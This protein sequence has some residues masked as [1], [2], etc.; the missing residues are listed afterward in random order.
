MADDLIY[1]TD[2]TPNWLSNVDGLGMACLG[3]TILLT[4]VSILAV[5]LRMF[6]RIEAGATGI[7]D[8][9]MVIATGLF[10]TDSIFAC[11][12]VYASLGSHDAREDLTDWNKSA[13]VM[14][15]I[16]WQIAYAWCL[17]FIKCSICFSLFRITSELKYRLLL[18]AVMVL[19]TV[20]AM[21]GFI[22]VVITCQP[23]AKNWDPVIQAD[24]N[25]GYCMTGN[26]VQNLSYYVSASSIVTDWACAIIPCFIVWNLQMKR[27]LKISVAAILALGA[28]ASVTTIVR[29]PYLSAYTAPTDA[30][31]QIANI[32]IWSEIECGVGI[33]AGS[34]PALRRFVKSILDK[35]SKGGSYD[36][37][38][39]S[40]MGTQT[41]GGGK[42]R[43]HTG[44]MSRSVKMSNLSRNGN[45]TV[46]EAG[47]KGGKN[48]NN[49]NW[50]ELEDDSESQKHIIT[51]TNEISVS[52]EESS[53]LERMGSSS[54]RRHP[55]AM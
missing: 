15:L 31:Y 24:T 18:W 22:A 37:R 20:S 29:L 55:Q 3:I 27:K 2:M 16:L 46:I 48:H 26:I 14:Y 54:I 42:G 40:G 41:I 35:S 4:I 52:V 39:G 25:I 8:W 30:Y 28:V 11:L 21:V 23:M 50:I 7:D 19:A 36:P 6:A 33:I 38:S 47:S 45:N 44:K 9:L 5:S 1:F 34:L 53:D 17:P 49:G 13:V 32:V 12:D 51:Q 10:T 43:S